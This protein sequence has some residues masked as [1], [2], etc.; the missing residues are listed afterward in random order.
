[1]T[2][3]PLPAAIEY[4]PEVRAR[5]LSALLDEIE[6]SLSATEVRQALGPQLSQQFG[7]DLQGCRQRLAAPF[8]LVVL[9]DFKRGKSTLINALLGAPAVTTNIAPET[10]TINQLRYG[11]APLAEI[12]LADGGRVRLNHDDLAA[13]RLSALLERLPRPASHMVVEYP[14]DWLRGVMLVDTPGLNDV[15]QRFDQQVSSYL[16]QADAV[17]YVISAQAPLAANERDFLRSAVRPQDFPKIFFIV[18]M[19]DSF[20]TRAQAE[21]VLASIRAKLREAFPTA[22]VLG[23]SALD[24]FAR[25][26]GE[27]PPNPARAAELEQSFAGLRRE[28]NN[29]I[30]L[31]RQVIQLDRVTAMAQ[32]MLAR[33]GGQVSRLE[34]ALQASQAQLEQGLAQCQDHNSAL[35]RRLDSEK[36]AIRDG[37]EGLRLEAIGWMADFIERVQS[38][39]LQAVEQYPPDEVQRH[40]LPFLQDK[41]LEALNA[42][43][44]AQQGVLLEQLGAAQTALHDS[45]PRLDEQAARP[46]LMQLSIARASLQAQAWNQ[47]DVLTLVSNISGLGLGASL[48]AQLMAGLLS[49]AGHAASRDQQTE[50]YTRQLR[51]TLPRLQQAAADEVSRV[52]GEV[53]SQLVAQLQATAQSE[54]E[55]ALAALQQAQALRQ[56]SGQSAA[57]AQATLGAFQG[58]VQEFS[59]RLDGF[60][61]KLRQAPLLLDTGPGR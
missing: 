51:V 15:L 48:L 59:S 2:E 57:A 50:A 28:L 45:L 32:A 33:F 3:P 38:E 25:S 39:A 29:S 1:M 26:Q 4:P 61:D 27:A 41:L 23:V 13:E 6:A 10:V 54:I 42:C 60:K 36:Q 17:L 22:P 24:E 46:E 43:L 8:T 53:G 37:V 35:F 21:R 16:P 11:P 34:A 9:G 55:A 47:L 31:N 7:A 40:L 52:Y 12:H 5:E 18:N 30:L 20:Q 49:L 19:L 44:A 14:N 56:Q 58:Q